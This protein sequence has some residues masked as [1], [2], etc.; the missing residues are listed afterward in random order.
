MRFVKLAIGESKAEL[1][2]RIQKKYKIL[3]HKYLSKWKILCYFAL[4]NI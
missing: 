3:I 4:S 1:Q 2:K